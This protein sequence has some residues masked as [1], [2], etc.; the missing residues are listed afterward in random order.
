MNMIAYPPVLNAKRIVPLRKSLPAPIRKV[1]M[2]RATRAQLAMEQMNRLG[3]KTFR[4]RFMPSSM[5][6]IVKRVC[7]KHNA[8]IM[9]VASNSRSRLAVRTRN[10]AMYL[11]KEARPKLSS[12]QIARWFDRD[13]TS[14]LHGIAGHALKNCLP[15]LVGFNFE[16]VVARNARIAAEKRA[17]E[18]A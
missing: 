16:R 18:A 2:D 15:K 10:E 8:S 17:M 4:S 12:F 7:Q 14:V 6:D 11:I 5:L 1:A 9:L 3:I 13:H